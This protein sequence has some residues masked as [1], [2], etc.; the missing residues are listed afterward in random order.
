[1]PQAATRTNTITVVINHYYDVLK[2][3]DTNLTVHVLGSRLFVVY[4][5][6]VSLTRTEAL[7]LHKVSGNNSW[8]LGQHF[9]FFA[10]RTLRVAFRILIIPSSVLHGGE[11]LS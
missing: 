8:F 6:C 9:N 5:T 3:G 2:G 10:H 11:I 4:D 1:V 7:L